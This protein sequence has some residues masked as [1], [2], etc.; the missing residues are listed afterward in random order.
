MG[1]GRGSLEIGE[2]LVDLEALA[3]PNGTFIGNMVRLKAAERRKEYKS[4][5]IK[6]KSLPRATV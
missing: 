1:F 4:A 3:E 2:G 5:A 6:N